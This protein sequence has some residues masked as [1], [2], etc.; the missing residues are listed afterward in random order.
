MEKINVLIVEDA[1]LVAEDIANKL[2]KHNMDVA[3]ICNSGEDAIRSLEERM[4]DVILMDIQLSGALDGISTAHMIHEKNDIPIVY[5]S[6]YGDDDKV[7]RAIK[8]SPQTYLSKPFREGDLIRTIQIA[9]NNWRDRH[10]TKPSAVLKDHFFI[11]DGDKHVKVSYHDIVYL[12]AGRAYCRIVTETKTYTQSNNMGKILDQIS[13]KDF[14]RVHRSYVINT[15]KITEIEG[16]IIRLGKHRVEMSKGMR[17][18][19]IDKLKFI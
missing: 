18:K 12:E 3:A 13:H 8:T 15:N 11:K 9:F 17:D 1:G 7:N 6:D 4:P 16:N 10:A 2:K 14:I 19:L 5:L